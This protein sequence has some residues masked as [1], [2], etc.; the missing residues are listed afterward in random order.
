MKK[1][2]KLNIVY[3]DKH[4]L[5]VNKPSNL[6]T[7]ATL[8][9]S[10]NTLYHQILLYL[11][12]KNQKVFIV[13][14]LDKDTSGLI[15]FAKSLTTKNILQNNW[16]NVS[17]KYM[18]IV[19]GNFLEK[20]KTLKSY[21]KET[22]TNYVYTTN[23]KKQGKLAILRYKVI[24]ENSKYSLLDIDIK[25]GRKNQIRVQLNSINHPI[26]GDKKYSQNK[27][28]VKKLYLHAYYLK[29]NHPVTNK[30][31]IVELDIPLEFLKFIDKM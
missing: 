2:E 3:E 16:L 29:F 23:D 18:A 20:E 24:W 15:I 6:L 12:K 31:I 27:E 30:Q 4:I 25:T 26:V 8:K 5:I 10:E 13:H 22:K 9:E 19:N 7:I 28:K 17:R 1:N 21:L 11:K 14:R